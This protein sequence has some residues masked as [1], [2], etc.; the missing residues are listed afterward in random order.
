MI[1]KEYGGYNVFSADRDAR[2]SFYTKRNLYCLNLA[3]S[4]LELLLRARKPRRVYAPYYTCHSVH[5]VLMKMVPQV[6]YYHIDEE[7]YPIIP[8]LK[9][10]DDQLILV[11][12][13][14]GVFHRP[15]IFLIEKYGSKVIVDNSQS[16]YSSFPDDIDQ[17]FSPRKLFGV[18]DGGFVLTN[19]DITELYQGLETDQSAGR[20]KYLFVG[21]ETSKNEGYA[22][23]L[24][25][26]KR[27]QE[28][29]P[30][31]M[32]VST[33]EIF[34]TIDIEY[35][36]RK[37]IMNFERMNELIGK[38]NQMDISIESGQVPMC[39]PFLSMRHSLKQDLIKSRVYVPTYWPMSQLA[40]EISCFEKLL[41]NNLCCLPVD[42]SMTGDD[43]QAVSELVVEM[44]NDSDV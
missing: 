27:L 44:I 37:R 42:Q 28:L 1:R 16:F 24:Q 31:K 20:I 34:K 26:R 3:R 2:N 12:N 39:Y 33:R 22:E 5:E 36:K 11:N 18:T 23:Y 35:C 10:S 41:R 14:F 25:Y 15:I 43:I 9:L 7:F 21:D 40:S 30:M 32:S 8:D 29:E 38:Y 4:G 19:A 13:Y 17:I 6:R